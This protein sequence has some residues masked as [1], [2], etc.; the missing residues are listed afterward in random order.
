M[1]EIERVLIKC[2][3]LYHYI[4]EFLVR[5]SICKKL[6]ISD[7]PLLSEPHYPR[8]CSIRL[9]TVNLRSNLKVHRPSG[10]QGRSKS[11]KCSQ[12]P[13]LPEA[14]TS[15]GRFVIGSMRLQLG[16]VTNACAVIRCGREKPLI[17]ES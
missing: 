7:D 14:V 13:R 17:W 12:V 16:N 3:I 2:T 9:S 4:I 10:C 15:V 5:D 1:L 6:I 11:R 8:E